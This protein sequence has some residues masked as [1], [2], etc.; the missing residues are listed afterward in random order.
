MESRTATLKDVAREAQ[1]S[2]QTVSRAVNG[3]S[4][5]SEETRE[6]VMAICRKLGYRPNR[7]AGSL[8]AKHSKV[9][10]LVVSDI[11]NAYFAEVVSGAEAETTA[12]GW[13]LLLANS[14]ED[15]QRE[16]NAVASLFERRVDGL[17][18]APAEGNHAYLRKVLPSQFPVVSFNRSIDLRGCGAVLTENEAGAHQAVRYLISRGHRKIGA[19]VASMGLMTSRERV[20]GFRSAMA[21]GKLHVKDEW[22]SMGGVHVDSARKAALGILSQPNRPT[23]LLTS[24]HRVTEGV[25]HALKEL[26]LQYGKDVEIVSFDKVPWATFL[27]PPL[28]MVAQP[29]RQIGQ[30]A[31]RML[32]AMIDGTGKPSVVRL[33]VELITHAAAT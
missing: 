18:I 23:A 7:L 24:S 29:T 11:E 25:M 10:G 1:V 27:E 26:G 32:M 15:L 22:I 16:Q 20:A 33:P 28:P 13:S 9:I 5:I 21:E 17:I 2:M 19:L 12:H 14:G 6:R 3:H 4:E 8:R 31:V 30:E